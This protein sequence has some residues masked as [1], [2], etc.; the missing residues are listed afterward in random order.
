MT[1]QLMA[2]LCHTFRYCPSMPA[3]ENAVIPPI[4]QNAGYH[5]ECYQRYTCKSKIDRQ[6]DFEEKRKGVYGNGILNFDGMDSF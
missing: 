1:K 3:G 5:R 2:Y 6:K 4:P